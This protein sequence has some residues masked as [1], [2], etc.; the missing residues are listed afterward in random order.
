MGEF[1]ATQLIFRLAAS[2]GV[3]CLPALF[4]SAQSLDAAVADAVPEVPKDAPFGSDSKRPAPR[5][6]SVLP[7]ATPARSSLTA[8]T[9]IA[10]DDPFGDQAGRI[11]GDGPR[12]AT[13]F[14]TLSQLVRWG[15]CGLVSPA[16]IVAPQ[17]SARLPESSARLRAIPPLG[18]PRA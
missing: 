9:Q 7:D 10:S 16:P 18:P 8:T 17:N 4:R 6:V 12:T 5:L 15:A 13:A 14:A 3:L 2:L 11:L 1:A